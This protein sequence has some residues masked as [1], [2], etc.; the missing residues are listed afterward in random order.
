MIKLFFD[1]DI[2]LNDIYKKIIIIIRTPKADLV[3][4]YYNSLQ[5]SKM[6]IPTDL[7]ELHVKTTEKFLPCFKYPS[8]ELIGKRYYKLLIIGETGS[9]KAILL[10]TFVKN[11]QV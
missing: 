6:P 2:T 7:K 11:L 4:Q 10:D 8:K 9:E 5:K 1:N 3:I